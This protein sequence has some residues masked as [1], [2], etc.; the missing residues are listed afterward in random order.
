MKFKVERQEEHV[1]KTFRMPKGLIEKMEA[2]AST[3]NIS[4]NRLVIL[5]VKYA[6]ENM[7]DEEE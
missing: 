1:T 7:E 5:C 4:L 6:L 3:K 2:I